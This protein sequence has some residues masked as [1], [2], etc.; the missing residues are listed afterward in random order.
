MRL[1]SEVLLPRLNARTMSGPTFTP[2]RRQVLSQ[3]RGTVLEIGFGSGLNLPHYPAKEVS[4][5]S[6]VEPNP[7][8]NKLAQK[9]IKTSA[10]EVEQHGGRAEKL[11]F[12]DSTFDTVVSTWTLCSLAEVD[13]AL[14]EV[15]RV[16][17]PGGHFLFVEHG[18]NPDP[19]I[20]KWQQRLDPLQAK[21]A[22]GCHLNRDIAAYIKPRLQILELKQFADPRLGKLTGYLY[23]GKAVRSS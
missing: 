2:Y 12:A 10:I 7:G 15:R 21:V 23:L 1:W 8:S 9:Q 5:L 17:K 6:I 4:K 16:L 19:K 22:G 14:E 20:Q 13:Q 3:A 11:P 18:L